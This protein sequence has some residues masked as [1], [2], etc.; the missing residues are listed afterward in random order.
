[1]AIIISKLRQATRISDYIPVK[2]TARNEVTGITVAGPFS[3]KIIN[4]SNI[5]SC[6]LMKQV[7]MG[8][9]HI[10]HSTREDNS[11]FLQLTIDLPPNIENVKIP[12]QPVWMDLFHQDDVRA[13]K[14]GVEFLLNPEDGQKKIKKLLAAIAHK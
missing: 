1:M 6:L 12:T 2:V 13:F 9:Y 11:L 14:M 7:M 8:S 3:G 4:I 5:G 10:F